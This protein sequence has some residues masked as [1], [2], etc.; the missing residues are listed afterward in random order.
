M[1][2][3]LLVEDEKDLRL[4]LI[5]ILEKEGFKV[6]GVSRGK[7]A[8]KKLNNQIWQAVVLD[9]KLPDM[10]GLEV[11][12]KT[13]KEIY[14]PPQ[15]IIISAYGSSQVRREAKELGCFAFLDKP[16]RIK[17]FLQLIREAI[18]KERR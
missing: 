3:V 13:K 5:K 14:S 2:K 7:D 6:E 1:Q 11:L 17:R 15:V 10:N 12:R 16:F 9:L 18:K 4:I 8:I